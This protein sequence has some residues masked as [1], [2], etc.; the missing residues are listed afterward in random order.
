ME[1]IQ[2]ELKLLNELCENKKDESLFNDVHRADA[3]LEIIGNYCHQLGMSVSGMVA[4]GNNHCIESEHLLDL[5][6]K[7]VSIQ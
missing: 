7:C 3:Q 5:L 6:E 4:I 2:T 1:T